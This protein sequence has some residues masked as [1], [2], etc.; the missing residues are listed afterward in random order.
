MHF[1]LLLPKHL[2]ASQCSRQSGTSPTISLYLRSIS[3]APALYYIIVIIQGILACKERSWSMMNYC[4]INAAFCYPICKKTEITKLVGLQHWIKIYMKKYHCGGEPACTGLNA[5]LMEI[6]SEQKKLSNW[7][8]HPL[9]THIS[10]KYETHGLTSGEHEAPGCWFVAI[11]AEQCIFPTWRWKLKYF[12]SD[13]GFCLPTAG[14]N[15]HFKTK[16]MPENSA[17]RNILHVSATLWS[18]TEG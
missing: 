1:L 4:S 5:L 17:K 2:I 13:N 16:T 11:C 12:Q 6:C 3:N 14:E 15:S 9:Y 10:N 18:M 7:E 8:P